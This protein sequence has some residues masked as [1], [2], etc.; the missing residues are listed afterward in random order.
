MQNYN[1]SINSDLRHKASNLLHHFFRELKRNHGDLNAMVRENEESIQHIQSVDNEPDYVRITDCGI[2]I[3]IPVALEVISTDGLFP[4][5]LIVKRQ[6]GKVTVY[7]TEDSDSPSYKEN[8]KALHRD[9]VKELSVK[10][11]TYNKL[12]IEAS[13]LRNE[14]ET[15]LNRIRRNTAT[16]VRNFGQECAEG[17]FTLAF[18]GKNPTWEGHSFYRIM[19]EDFGS[20]EYELRDSQDNYVQSNDIRDYVFLMEIYEEVL[21]MLS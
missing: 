8:Y 13:T 18:N 7:E 6:E 15:H 21:D 10:R 16:L 4:D 20:S 1:K 14:L 19:V 5:R 3:E 11:D 9:F 2:A 12:K 17:V